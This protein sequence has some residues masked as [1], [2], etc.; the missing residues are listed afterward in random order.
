MENKSE[1]IRRL[2]REG[3]G[4]SEIAKALGL[5]YQRVYNTLKR[6]GLLKP[7]A[8]GE[9]DPEAYARFIQG[10]DIRS[11]ELVE[12][13]AK[14]ERPPK[15]KL[16]FKMGLEA[17]GPEPR[18]GGFLAGLAL[19]LDFQDEEG[20]FGFLR[21]R[22]RAGYATPLFPDEALFRAFRERNLLLHLWPYLRLYVDFLTAQMG[23]PRLVLPPWKV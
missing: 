8:E 6:S 4:V 17:F 10:L 1:T 15:G 18:E 13:H 21:L 2:Y 16:A 20:P 12:A 3:K 11:V 5:S 9:P 19:S 7:K 22:V 23:L 14:L